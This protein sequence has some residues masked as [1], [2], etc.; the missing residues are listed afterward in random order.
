ME[1]ILSTTLTRNSF[2]MTSEESGEEKWGGFDGG[3]GGGVSA[4]SG[5]YFM[6]IH[7]YQEPADTLL[8][9][10]PIPRSVDI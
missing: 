5:F 2:S 9:L 7:L 6:G 4:M 8:N 10:N 3:E 1:S